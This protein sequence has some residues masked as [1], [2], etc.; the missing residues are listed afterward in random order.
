MRVYTLDFGKGYLLDYVDEMCV[1][2]VLT[3]VV[4]FPSLPSK[5]SPHKHTSSTLYICLLFSTTFLS[6]A[7][8]SSSGGIQEQKEKC[9]R[10]GPLYK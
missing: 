8:W 7:Y 10:R 1:G 5:Y 4:S 9:C 6:Y 3:C 2:V